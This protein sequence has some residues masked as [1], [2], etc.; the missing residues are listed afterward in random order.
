MIVN[1]SIDAQRVCVREHPVLER[2]PG[3]SRRKFLLRILAQYG[4]T[5]YRLRVVDD[6]GLLALAATAVLVAQL[7]DWADLPRERIAMVFSSREGCRQTDLNFIDSM[8]VHPSARLFVQTLPN[9][10][11]GQVANYFGIRGENTWLMQA[12]RDRRQL[13]EQVE[14]LLTLTPATYCLAGWVE[15]SSQALEANLEWWSRAEWN[16]DHRTDLQQSLT[17]QNYSS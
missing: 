9:I 7:P 4:T 2:R 16:G 8:A 17:I 5:P 10:A 12:Q 13:I 15:C 11:M 3:E 1:C 6:A 14:L